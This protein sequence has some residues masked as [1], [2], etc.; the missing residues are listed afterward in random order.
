[1]SFR[2]VIITSKCKLSYKNDHL[3]VRGDELKLIHLSEIEILI[4]ESTQVLI[5]SYLLCE[6]VK[7]KI[8]VVFCNEKHNPDSQLLSLYGCHNSSKKLKQQLEWTDSIKDFVWT[9]IVTEKI[10]KQSELLKSQNKDEF[11]LL[12]EYYHGTKSGDSTNR[13]GHAAKV[14]FNALFGKDFTRDD[15]SDIN[16]AL[17]YGYTVL[18]SFFNREI[19]S[20]GYLTQLGL[21]HRS[22]FNQFNLSSDLMEPFRILIDELVY[23][24]KKEP[25]NSKYKHELVNVINKKIIIDKKTQYTSNAIKIY[26]KSIFKSLDLESVNYMKFYDGKF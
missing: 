1:M 14:Y 10:R 5:T 20:N 12:E 4:I 26:V 23:K 8:Y 6:L 11:K 7:R 13:E 17:D 19:V 21:W 2:T 16:K 22:E 3:Y 18:L 9:S 15:C 24:K 25:F